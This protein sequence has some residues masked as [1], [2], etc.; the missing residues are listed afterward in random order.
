MQQRQ[1]RNDDVPNFSIMKAKLSL[2]AVGVMAFSMGYPAHAEVRSLTLGI[3]VNCPPGL[4][5]CWNVGIGE[6]VARMSAIASIDEVADGITQT[7]V[8]RTKGGRLVNL[9]VLSQH[10]VDIQL[11]ARLRSTEAVV[12]GWLERRDGDVVLKISGTEESVLLAPL[13]K[14]TQWDRKQ[15]SEFAAT[16][17]EQKAFETLLANWPGGRQAVRIIGPLRPVKQGG[18]MILEVREAYCFGEE[19]PK[20]T[21]LDIGIRVSSPYGLG[22]PWS[23][24]RTTLL[25]FPGIA[26][27]A[28]VPDSINSLARIHSQNGLVPDLVALGT[29]LGRI[30]IGAEIRGVEVTMDGTIIKQNGQLALK[31]EGVSQ[32][33]SL[34]PMS[35][36]IQWDLRQQ[37]GAAPAVSEREAYQRLFTMPLRPGIPVKV[38]GPLVQTA[39]KWTLLEVRT[40][41]VNPPT[42][43]MIAA[44]K[45]R[46]EAPPAMQGSPR[47]IARA[48]GVVFLDWDTSLEDDV[49]GYHIYRSTKPDGRFTKVNRKPVTA[50][51]LELPG[52]RSPQ[53]Y[54][55]AVTAVDRAGNESPRSAAIDARPPAAP[56]HLFARAGDNAV[57]L[58]WDVPKVT[59]LDSYSIRRSEQAGGPYAVI[60]VGIT[61]CAYVDHGAENG[62]TYYYI[63]TAVDSSS[64]ESAFSNEFSMTP[65]QVRKLAAVPTAD[66]LAAR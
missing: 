19:A 8:V 20:F 21:A 66:S 12:D 52:S 6:G 39:D 38:T 15:N 64:N 55:Y 57:S 62:R 32:P 7:A 13:T 25:K 41:E 31:L 63:V 53:K 42:A 35:H 56:K 17:T 45:V 61:S 58:E 9:E 26:S 46:D 33:L 11:G 28:E 18:E 14:K 1:R 40:F 16:E 10:I 47:A 49:A 37:R 4:G 43:A 50:S 22:E 2:L 23:E 3:N 44:G 48:K 34:A 51:E 60:G 30:G 65:T 29:Q 36:K 59:D 5:E 24:A 54:F 27:V